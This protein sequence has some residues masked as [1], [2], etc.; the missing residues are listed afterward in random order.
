MWKR[1]WKFVARRLRV[2]GTIRGDQARVGI[3]VSFGG[4]VDKPE[5]TPNFSFNDMTWTSNREL[6]QKNRDE[7][8]NYKK[9][10]FDLAITLEGLRTVTGLPII[11][12]SAFRCPALNG[13]TAGSSKTS[14][15]MK[16]EAADI[17]Y[18]G[19]NTRPDRDEL[20]N[21][22][23]KHFVE[24]GVSWG[25]LIK[26]EANRSYGKAFWIHLSLGEPYREA[27]RCNQ[28]LEAKDGVY[29]F[30]KAIQHRR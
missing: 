9:A 24:N 12:Y 23:L 30:I 7:A 4:P 6:R 27:Y 22:I 13:S 10:L 18:D 25:Q 26:E 20:F 2:L 8:K 21:K 16:G 5:F 11:V 1:F 19:M 3:S 29:K 14:Q 15:H 17:G 28:V